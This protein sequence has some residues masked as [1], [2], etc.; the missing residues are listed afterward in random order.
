MLG[1]DQEIQNDAK[2]LRDKAF[3]LLKSTEKLNRHQVKDTDLKE[4]LKN[5]VPILSI[6]LD[7]ISPMPTEQKGTPE[8]VNGVRTLLDVLEGSD[9]KCFEVDGKSY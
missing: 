2:K 4:Y 9:N 1:Q 3:K 8:P 6:G 5:A 7:K